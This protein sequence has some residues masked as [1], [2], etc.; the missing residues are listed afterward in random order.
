MTFPN[1]STHPGLHVCRLVWQQIHSNVRVY[2]AVDIWSR[3]V[4]G[5]QDADH[6]VSRV[7]ETRRPK[8]RVI[9]ALLTSMLKLRAD[10]TAQTI[11]IN[12]K[13][14]STPSRYTG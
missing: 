14:L 8:L 1:L 9:T 6:Q 7:A 2:A 12:I 4:L 13:S 11:F 10:K 3:K 5:F